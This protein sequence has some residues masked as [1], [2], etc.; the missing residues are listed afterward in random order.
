MA[1]TE[2]RESVGP[3]DRLWFAHVD[4]P[5]RERRAPRWPAE[6]GAGYQFPDLKGQRIAH[7]APDP[8]IT[9]DIA[10]GVGDR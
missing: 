9:T 8:A 7:A 6:P 10:P 5:G 4:G 2:R 1:E 3:P